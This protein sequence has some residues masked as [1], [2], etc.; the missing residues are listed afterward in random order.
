[1]KILHAGCGGTI[2][3]EKCGEGFFLWESYCTKC[4]SCDPNGWPTRRKAVLEAV[5]FFSRKKKIG[6][7]HV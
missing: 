3:I 1:M 7:A 5:S 6:R 2:A 4:L